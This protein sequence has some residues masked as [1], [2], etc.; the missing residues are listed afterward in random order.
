MQ[1]LPTV[2]V[3]QSGSASDLD[4]RKAVCANMASSLLMST[5]ICCYT[6]AQNNM[7]VRGASQL[8]LLKDRLCNTMC[9]IYEDG[10]TM[11]NSPQVS[12]AGDA[13]SR[14]CVML[15]EID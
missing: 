2:L 7:P 15:G 9:W 4:R 13:L 5:T 3:C 10:T 14:C 11:L 6:I 12:F 1:A 8:G